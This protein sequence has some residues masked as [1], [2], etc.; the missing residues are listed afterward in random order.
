M[1]NK[2]NIWYKLFNPNSLEKDDW[3][4]PSDD[5]LA[6]I[7]EEIYP[8]K[9]RRWIALLLPI[10]LLIFLTSLAIYF[11]SSNKSAPTVSEKIELQD[12]NQN[13][14]GFSNIKSN[15]EQLSDLNISSA[16][17]KVK[18]EIALQ[19]PIV[20]A[21]A[22]SKPKFNQKRKA[23]S[24]FSHNETLNSNKAKPIKNSKSFL[25]Q[26]DNN[27]K[28]SKEVNNSLYPIAASEYNSTLN[29]SRSQTDNDNTNSALELLNNLPSLQS[30]H[31][32]SLNT[33]LSFPNI[34]QELVEKIDFAPE[35]IEPSNDFNGRFSLVSGVAYTQWRFNL[36]SNYQT[37]LEPA[38]FTYDNGKGVNFFLGLQKEFNPKLS[39]SINFSFETIDFTSGHNSTVPVDNSLVSSDIPLDMA[40]PLGIISSLVNVE[41]FGAQQATVSDVILDLNNEHTVTNFDF[42]IQLEY[43]LFKNNFLRVDAILGPGVSYLHTIENRLASFETDSDDYG[44][45]TTEITQNQNNLRPFRIHSRVGFNAT[46]PTTTKSQI[47]FRALYLSDLNAIYNN[48]ED[49]STSLSR[50]N[51]GAYYKLRF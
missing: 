2:N 12:K 27:L 11:F 24:G 22:I 48:G 8:V 43:A 19:S 15:E 30:S 29:E 10:G 50:I 7:E 9:K 35:S 5:L 47:G 44:S 20:E 34:S 51:I 13:T 36:N 6:K 42:G 41:N 17:K 32:K 31:P 37:A 25:S 28:T 14:T 16:N 33:I 49:F 38:D 1:P 21:K 4:D 40:T 39:A 45:G 23:D 18:D 3:L 26:P 46:V